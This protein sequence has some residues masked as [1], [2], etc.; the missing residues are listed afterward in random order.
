MKWLVVAT[1]VSSLLLGSI[2]VS[3]AEETKVPPP[4]VGPV[5]PGGPPIGVPMSSGA[6]ISLLGILSRTDTLTTSTPQAPYPMFQLLG[7]SVVGNAP[8][9][10]EAIGN[11][12]LLQ[13]ELMIK[14][15][16]VLMKYGQMMVE[17]GR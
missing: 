11:L 3:S 8:A 17:R 5:Q 13:G 10:P 2:G 7:P 16:E 4:P 15:G 1:A 14:M 9:N 12:L 6:L